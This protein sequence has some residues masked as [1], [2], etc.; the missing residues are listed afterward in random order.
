MQHNVSLEEAQTLLLNVAA[1][2]NPSKMPLS[3][4][5]GRVLCQDVV[6]QHNIPAFKKSAM[7]GYAVIASDTLPASLSRPVRLTVVEEIRAGSVAEKAVNPGTTIKVQT[8]APIPQG[9]DAVI[10]YEDVDREGDVIFITRALPPGENVVPVGEDVKQGDIIARRGT[11]ITPPMVGVFA[12]LGMNRVPVFRKVRISISN[13][14]DE[15]LD[16]SQELQPG[17]IYN[18]TLF[19]LA[20]RCRELGTVP[21]DLGIS[22]DDVKATTA[23]IARGLEISDI[24]LITGGVS[25]GDFDVV[26]DSLL[27][28]GA[29]ILLRGVAMKPGSPMIAAAKDDKIIIGLSGNPA[30]AMVNFELIV[31]PFIKRVMG[32]RQALPPKFQG[33]MANNYPKSSP[34]RRF[35]RARLLRKDGKDFVELTG[36]QGN[37]V[38]MS[39]IDCNVLVDVPAGSGPVTLGQQVSGFLVGNLDQAYRGCGV[40]QEGSTLDFGHL[41]LDRTASSRRSSLVNS[42]SA[43]S[44]CSTRR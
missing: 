27:R 44:A 5:S 31:V 4:A 18:R 30:A 1:P 41:T 23:R 20:A 12:G 43:A 16:P 17:K 11:M 25:V 14:G 7:D 28:A 21:I 37:G 24:V 19:A 29:T 42:R 36:A 40:T 8:G 38:L 32:L 34:Q 22:P 39:L 35:L 15:L 9:A 6:A 3:H 33:I 2:V 26:K 13:T 10:K